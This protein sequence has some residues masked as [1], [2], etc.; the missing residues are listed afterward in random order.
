MYGEGAIPP[1]WAASDLTGPAGSGDIK[2]CTI[3]QVEWLWLYCKKAASQRP[4]GHGGDSLYVA[5]SIGIN[6][7]EQRT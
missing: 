4:P 3:H 5:V 7:V 6:K 2:L 1:R